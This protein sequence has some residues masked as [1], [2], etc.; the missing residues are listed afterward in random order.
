MQ[1]SPSIV[2]CGARVVKC[3][4]KLNL[5]YLADCASDTDAIDRFLRSSK[6]CV[7]FRIIRSSGDRHNLIRDS[8][9]DCSIP[10]MIHDSDGNKLA[11]TEPD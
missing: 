11:T 6:V 9:V 8:I 5:G 10:M 2:H 3:R 4:S 7:S 1:I